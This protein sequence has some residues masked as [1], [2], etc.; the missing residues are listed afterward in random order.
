VF[1]FE[2]DVDSADPLARLIVAANITSGAHVVQEGVL[3]GDEE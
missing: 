1:N 3:P 2:L